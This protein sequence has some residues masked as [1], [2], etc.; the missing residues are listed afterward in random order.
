M[1][2]TEYKNIVVVIDNPVPSEMQVDTIYLK[3]LEGKPN[4][5]FYAFFLCPC[6]C[7]TLIALPVGTKSG[8]PSWKIQGTDPV[9]LSPSI[10]QLKGCQSHFFIR[11]N[12]VDWC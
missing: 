6:S 7:Q 12:R 4:D 9:T 2:L 3:V 5:P 11:Q 8:T 1:K 10:R